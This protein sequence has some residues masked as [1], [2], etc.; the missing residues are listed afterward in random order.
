MAKNKKKNK[1]K[2]NKKKI[3]WW[4][5]I[6]R[7]VFGPLLQ[8]GKE[9]VKEAI[10]E[11]QQPIEDFAILAINATESII[12]IYTDLE[13]DNKQ[14][15][16]EWWTAN[17]LE[18]VAVSLSLI[19]YAAKEIALKIELGNPVTEDEKRIMNINRIIKGLEE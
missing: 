1:K 9:A 15:M 5:G 11:T 10:P 8:M 7:W 2:N 12:K 18:V 4:K 19:T 3:G 16:G 17:K 13:K 14:Q 6:A